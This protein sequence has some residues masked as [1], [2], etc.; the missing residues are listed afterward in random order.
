MDGS[1]PRFAIVQSYRGA[2]RMTLHHGVVTWMFHLIQHPRALWIL[3]VPQCNEVIGYG[4]MM[5]SLVHFPLQRIP[6]SC[7]SQEGI[8]RSSVSAPDVMSAQRF[9]GF[10]ADFTFEGSSDSRIGAL[11]CFR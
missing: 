10:P 2:G 8:P 1:S 6:T 7:P 5:A 11:M 4:S 3:M 9:C